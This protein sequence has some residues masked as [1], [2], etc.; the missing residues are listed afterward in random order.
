MKTN[1]N[2]VKTPINLVDTGQS[3]KN[4]DGKNIKLRNNGKYMKGSK[5]DI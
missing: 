1:R 3:A 4:N 5:G 2:K